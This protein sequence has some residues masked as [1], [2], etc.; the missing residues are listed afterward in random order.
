METAILMAAGMGTRML[1]ITNNTPKPLV[2][3]NGIPMIETIINALNYRGVEK[4]Y[5]VVGYLGEQ[6]YY[7]R[8]QYHNI[9]IV[10]NKEYSTANN[11]SSLYAIKDVLGSAN[12]FICEADLYISDKT[13][14]TSE[15]LK[16]CY[17]GKMIMGYSDDWVFDIKNGRIVRIGKGGTDCYNMVGISY[18]VKSDAQCLKNW[19]CTMYEQSTCRELFWDEVVNQHLDELHLEIH[20]VFDGQIVEIDTVKELCEIDD[21]YKS[22]L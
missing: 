14:F 21:S 3:V 8:D 12:C 4:I 6:F 17:F 2:K 7:L 16:S 5:I 19:I 11:I 20:D 22:V 10:E 18:F 13:I 1:P 9:V 15:R